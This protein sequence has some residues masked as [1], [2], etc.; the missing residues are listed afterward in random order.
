MPDRRDIILIGGKPLSYRVRRHRRARSFQVN[1]SPG[2]GVEVVIPWRASFKDVPGLMDGWREWLQEKADKFDCWQGPQVKQY[3]SGSQLLILGRLCTLE[4]SA[5]P[6]GRSR[7]RVTL[8][9]DRLKMALPPESIWD[10]R[11]ALEKWLRKLARRE[12]DDRLAHW[13]Q[14]TG[15]HPEKVIIGDRK[16]RWGSCSSRKTLS[17]CYRLVMATPDVIDAV[18]I[19]E[20]CHLKHLNHSQRFYALLERHSPDHL[21]ARAWLRDN[22]DHLQV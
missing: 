19:H 11:P 20:L 5:L 7:S 15:L 17:F 2:D 21:E 9:A 8:E 16:T 13:T 3:A 10:P 1:V 4:V 12:L 18:I 22:H 6:A 14:V